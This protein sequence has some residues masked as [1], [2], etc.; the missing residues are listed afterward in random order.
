[1][2]PLARL[3]AAALSLTVSAR[4]A[5][6]AEPGGSAAVRA[7]RLAAA[8]T[9]DEKIALVHSRFGMPLKG[10]AKPE[11][12]LDS[13]GFVP[14]IPR[15]GIP[16][17]QEADG[18]LGLANPTNR[19]YDATPMPSGLALAATF[20]ESL[21]ERA[22]RAIGGEAR[23]MGFS[24][25]LAGAANLTR[26]ARGGRDFEYAGEDPLL[27][28]R[29][30]GAEV[31]GI[32]SAPIVSTI[33]HFALNAQETGRVVLDARIDAAAARESDLLAFELA[34]ERGRPG[35]VMTSYNNVDGVHASQSKTLIDGVLKE[36][37]G[38][39]G[40]VMSDWGGTHSTV[41]AANAGLDQE[42]GA[43][44]DPQAYFG[45]PLAA[46]VADGRVTK[47]RL[48]DMVVRQLAA[49]IA[50]GELDDPAHPR[51]I[52]NLPAHAGLA[53]EIAT[54]GIVLLKNRDGALPLGTAVKSVLVV[55]GHADLG[56][57]SGGGS[58]QV[59]PKGRLRFPGDP[60]GAFLWRA[61]ALRSVAASCRVAR[62]PARRPN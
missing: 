14:G 39:A 32:Q 31:A 40:W 1:M 61:Q 44:L 38:F 20:D 4:A 24:V 12:A 34:L 41:A 57:L 58:S 23:D 17:L 11:G 54:R 27:A 2:A 22:G 16:P 48:D 6:A 50:A 28:G 49:R 45:A 36:D 35:A 62:R 42:S 51:P 55:G 8:L 30:V 3:A 21:A 59:V 19:D 43:D 7:A 25:L 53:K 60:P 15:L 10:R 26:E 13:A 9:L 18:S 52:R 37:W 5:C 56:V 47:A 33:K 29:I 46:A